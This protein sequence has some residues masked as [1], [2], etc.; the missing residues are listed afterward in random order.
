MH[1]AQKVCVRRDLCAGAISRAGTE[2]PQHQ[3]MASPSS[4]CQ[5]PGYPWRHAGRGKGALQK[6]W[7]NPSE[8]H[9]APKTAML[10]S[11][12]S[13]LKPL[14]AS[15]FAV[16]RQKK[17]GRE[18]LHRGAIISPKRE[19]KSGKRENIPLI[20]SSTLNLNLSHHPLNRRY[21]LNEVFYF[22]LQSPPLEFDGHQLI[23]THLRTVRVACQLL[24]H[25]EN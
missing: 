13:P 9:F 1:R 19:G 16:C 4:Q 24:L 21:L 23:G 20:A 7:A 12:E 17:E 5:D 25:E 6:S 15:V 22:A 14:L 18:E 10:F 2:E 11:K 8:K 3:G